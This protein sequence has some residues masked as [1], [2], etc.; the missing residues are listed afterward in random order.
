MIEDIRKT[1]EMIALHKNIN[2]LSIIIEQYEAIKARQVSEL[3]HDLSMPPFQNIESISVIKTIL[4]K[5]YPE[6]PGDLVKQKE[7]KELEESIL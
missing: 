6:L 2:D 4:N 5:F 3:I 1:D 7:L